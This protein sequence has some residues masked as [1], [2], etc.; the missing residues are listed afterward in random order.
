MPTTRDTRQHQHGILL[1]QARNSGTSSSSTSSACRSEHGTH[2][3]RRM[4]TCTAAQ[5]T[6]GPDGPVAGCKNMN[7]VAGAHACAY[8]CVKHVSASYKHSFSLS[9]TL[10]AVSVLLHF[11]GCPR[12]SVHC[13]P[14]AARMP[15]THTRKQKKK[16]N[17][18]RH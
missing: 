15:H 6:P 1:L 11:C 5:D 16:L 8:A 7:T 10:C 3:H 17:S 2:N 13:A 4:C 14:V 12:F 9:L 18:D